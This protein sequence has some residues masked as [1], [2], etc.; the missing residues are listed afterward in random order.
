MPPTAPATS[1][2]A[3]RGARPLVYVPNSDSNTVDVIDQRTFKVVEHFAVGALPQHVVPS[4]DLKTLYVTND[5]ATSLTPIDPRTGK[6]GRTIPVD[7]PY[8]MYFTPTA[9]TRSSSRSGCTG[10]TSA[11]A[12]TFKLQ[13]LAARSRAR[14]STTWTSLPTARYV[15]V[16][17]E[18]S[19]QMLKVDVARERVVGVLHAAARRG[20]AGRE[21]LARREGLLRRRHELERRLAGRRRRASRPAA[22]CRRARRARPLSEPRRAVPL[23]HESRRGLDLRHL[24]R[25]AA[26]S[27]TRGTSPAA[28]APTWGTS[29]PTARSCGCPAATT[30]SSTRSARANGRLLAKIPVGAGPHGLCVWPQPGRYSLGHT[31]ILR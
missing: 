22:S 21:A 25:D 6:P 28:A 27:C 10:S 9:A 14:A 13:S 16:S 29:R 20:A 24:V 8:N 7:D 31:G 15:I 12:H 17:C 18:F 23:R 1:A 3:A 11:I 5:A 2:P 4:W 30:A 26:R 19:G